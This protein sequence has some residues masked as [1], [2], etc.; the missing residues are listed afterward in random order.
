M[1]RTP[2]LSGALGLL[3]ACNPPPG[4]GGDP[5]SG[6]NTP[7]PPEIIT[8][9][10]VKTKYLGTLEFSDGRPTRETADKVYDHLTYLRAVE[11][12][13]SLMPAASLEAMRIGHVDNGLTA[14]NQVALTE[15]LMD[16]N[17]LFLTG[18][19]DT[20]YASA[21][22]DLERD[23]PTVVEVAR[24]SATLATMRKS[25]LQWYWAMRTKEARLNSQH[26]DAES[27]PQGGRGDNECVACPASL[28]RGQGVFH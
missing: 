2:I 23:G 26:E 22:L 24:H 3:L 15:D 12:F 21:I 4:H 9:D 17:P 25:S 18:N 7:I 28:L 6:Y 1:R 8:P 10:S 13:L 19:T 27:G 16:S 14:A 5:A 20:V 11:V